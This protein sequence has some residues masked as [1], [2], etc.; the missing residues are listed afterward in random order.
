MGKAKAGHESVYVP[1][2]PYKPPWSVPVLAP[3]EEPRNITFLGTVMAMGS[4]F[5]SCSL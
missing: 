3:R 1:A 2:P 4:H 5:R